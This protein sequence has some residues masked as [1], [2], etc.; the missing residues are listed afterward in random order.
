MIFKNILFIY[1][2]GA[3]ISKFSLVGCLLHQQVPN[4]F[5][6]SCKAKIRTMLGANIFSVY[7]RKYLRS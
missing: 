6:N 5:G 1:T 4:I 2:P 3:R 7:C